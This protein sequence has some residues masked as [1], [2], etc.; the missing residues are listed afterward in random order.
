MRRQPGS[1]VRGID[2]PHAYQAGDIRQLVRRFIWD[3]GP[4]ASVSPID[5]GVAVRLAYLWSRGVRSRA[6]GGGWLAGILGVSTPP[7][8]RGE[9]YGRITLWTYEDASKPG[10]SS[11]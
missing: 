5:L 7:C 2:T 8:A 6:I 9:R 11:D 1:C 3:H 10:V 4:K